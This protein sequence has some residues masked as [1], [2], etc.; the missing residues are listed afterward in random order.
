MGFESISFKTYILRLSK[1]IHP[2]IGMTGAAQSAFNNLTRI[3]IEKLVLALNQLM[4]RT[5]KLTIGSRDIEAAAR[6]ALP[7][8]LATGATEEGENA[9]D[10]YSETK[11]TRQEEKTGDD[12]M[13]PVSRSS[14][15]DIVFPV[16]RIQNIMMELAILSRKTDTAAVYLAAVCEYL[17]AE[18]LELAGKAAQENKRARITPRHIMLAVRNDKELYKFYK[19]SVFA[20]GTVSLIHES[21]VKKKKSS[22]RRRKP[23]ARKPAPKKPTPKKK[24]ASASKKKTPPS[25]KKTSASSIKKEAPKKTLKKRPSRR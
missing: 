1:T 21:T 14:M 9:V 3:N 24:S 18:V 2:D 6:L 16:T 5:N 19:N 13:S 25:K 7:G 8:E 20:G 23:A 15:A 4:L 12:K 17:S 10:R 22:S 11:V